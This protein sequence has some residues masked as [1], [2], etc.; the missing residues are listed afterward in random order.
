MI[1]ATC[2]YSLKKI[3]DDRGNDFFLLA[4]QDKILP[5]QCNLKL[6][7][8]NSDFTY[9]T[10]KFEMAWAK[11]K[12]MEEIF[13]SQGYRITDITPESKSYQNNGEV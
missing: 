12:S 13:E 10:V 3:T 8:N 7:Q 5:N 6:E 4:Y 9:I 1:L 2:P 11:D